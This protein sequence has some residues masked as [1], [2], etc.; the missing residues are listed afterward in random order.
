MINVIAN[1]F[2]DYVL[3]FTRISA[4]LFALPIF[5][6]NTTPVRVRIL[7]SMAIAIG[8]APFVQVFWKPVFGDGFGVEYF[9]AIILNEVF[10]GL[11]LGYVARLAFVG[12]VAAAH[13]VGFQMGFGTGTLFV[14]DTGEHMD[15]FS[16]LHRT[17]I[18]SIFLMMDL[19]H[20]FFH[21]IYRTFALIP[22]GLAWPSIALGE[23]LIKWSG[24]T[25]VVALQ[26]AAPILIAL[27]F[28]MAALG[29]LARA[30][31]QINIFTTSFPVSFAVGLLIYIATLGM[32]PSWMI[33]HHQKSFAHLQTTISNLAPRP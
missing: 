15:G 7:M 6:D 13:L 29:L 5:G 3:I 2:L 9:F 32:Y 23:S 33:D 14:A 31:P 22:A 24:E 20:M 18:M 30:V 11:I 28:A 21:A 16:L 12:V 8:F 25:L 10:I 26:I 4:I 19:H 1:N 17:L 27:M